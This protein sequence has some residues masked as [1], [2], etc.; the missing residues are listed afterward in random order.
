MAG[1][2][3]F[4]LDGSKEVLEGAGIERQE[5]SAE[6]LAAEEERVAQQLEVVADEFEQDH[7][8]SVAKA[9]NIEVVVRKRWDNIPTVEEIMIEV[10]EMSY[11]MPDREDA[12]AEAGETL[13][14]EDEGFT[15]ED[16]RAQL[17]DLSEVMAAETGRGVDVTETQQ[18]EVVADLHTDE[19][20]AAVAQRELDRAPAGSE[21]PE[22][23]QAEDQEAAD[24]FTGLLEE[25]HTMLKDGGFSQENIDTFMQDQRAAFLEDPAEASRD[26]ERIVTEGKQLED[27]RLQQEASEAAEA[28]S[29]VEEAEPEVEDA[30]P[31][32]VIENVEDTANVV[33]DQI[34]GDGAGGAD[35]AAR[36]EGGDPEPQLPAVRE[37]Q[38]ELYE[39]APGQEES[40]GEFGYES[41]LLKDPEFM[42]FMPE[43]VDPEQFEKIRNM[44]PGPEKDSLQE[45]HM[46][47]ILGA[48]SEY[49]QEHPEKAAAYAERWQEMVEQAP[50]LDGDLSASELHEVLQDMAGDDGNIDLDWFRDVLTYREMGRS[51]EGGATPEV[52]A[53]AEAEEELP[54]AEVESESTNQRESKE[55]KESVESD[56]YE[57]ELAQD[58][59]FMDAMR[60]F[61]PIDRKTFDEIDAMSPEEA[62]AK[63]KELYRQVD[64]AI[65]YFADF[66]PSAARK[67]A[68]K[69]EAMVD[70]YPQL[71]GDLSGEELR[72]VLMDMLQ[73]EFE[74][75]DLDEDVAFDVDPDFF[76]DVLA[77]R[78]IH[79]VL[80]SKKARTA[81][82]KAPTSESVPEEPDA[83]ERFVNS[84]TLVPEEESFVNSETLVPE[85]ESF[86]N[87]ET[88]VPEAEG[89]LAAAAAAEMLDDDTEEEAG[90]A[91]RRELPE[92]EPV[93]VEKKKKKKK[94]KAP[95]Q[96]AAAGVLGVGGLFGGLKKLWDNRSWF[97]KGFK[98]W[99]GQE[100][101][102]LG[103]IPGEKENKEREEERKREAK[104]RLNAK[105]FGKK[106][107]KKGKKKKR[108]A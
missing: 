60:R 30:E 82:E 64:Q 106:D 38:V 63:R 5:I 7:E 79:R 54:A 32:V 62:E 45:V 65:K 102:K 41:D 16:D 105:G 72:E 47:M 73:P 43:A 58:E 93:V 12:P 103:E 3:E 66:Q 80:E 92:L 86:V 76:R 26:L 53:S 33:T 42:F 21:A 15:H 75:M 24:A 49:A 13:V 36:V 107:K 78:T 100:E 29:E 56:A 81:W 4:N 59:G 99:I 8:V 34:L 11:T 1:D 101:H 14:P 28:A 71:D 85:A 68:D 87:S 96:L 19:G 84:E 2:E 35:A 18:A 95:D 97:T 25:Y 50:Q 74:A 31:T 10:G 46:E 61:E 48:A 98:Q 88:L 104:K 55:S 40:D 6:E 77:Y 51:L 23:A 67:Y 70:Q 91:P 90:E 39:R 17:E 69:W 22:S 57:S 9:Q 20:D 44:P 94:S 52:D 27:D 83:E 108:A 89:I 37:P